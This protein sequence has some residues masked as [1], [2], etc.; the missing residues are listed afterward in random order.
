[1][2]RGIKSLNFD[3]PVYRRTTESD[4]TFSLEKHQYHPGGSMHSFASSMEPLTGSPSGNECIWKRMENNKPLL[5]H[6]VIIRHFQWGDLRQNGT[7]SH[8]QKDMDQRILKNLHDNH[9]LKKDP[10]IKLRHHNMNKNRSSCCCNNKNNNNTEYRFSRSSIRFYGTMLRDN[11]KGSSTQNPEMTV[12]YSSFRYLIAIPLM[13]FL[14]EV[15]KSKW[16]YG[17]SNHTIIVILHLLSLPF[18]TNF[19]WRQRPSLNLCLF[20]CLFSYQNK[21]G[22]QSLYAHFTR[23][24]LVSPSF[25]FN[26]GN[27]KSWT[28]WNITLLICAPFPLLTI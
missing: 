18:Y 9:A 2:K 23:F 28:K 22:R 16:L 20:V 27:S 13:Y 7:G 15:Q 6:S 17:Y 21:H 25:C 24:W 26:P 1:M 19:R 8:T 3:N 5:V 14:H 11:K 12:N 4:D 10:I